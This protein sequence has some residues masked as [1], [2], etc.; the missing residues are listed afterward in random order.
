[1]TDD[2][3]PEDSPFVRQCVSGEE[4]ITISI[5]RSSLRQNK[6]NE[7]KVRVLFVVFF[8]LVL[9]CRNDFR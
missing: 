4:K 2:V 8:L 6:K 9:V 5:Q 7:L 1:M 3:I